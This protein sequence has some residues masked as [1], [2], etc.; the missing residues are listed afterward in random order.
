MKK[1][2]AIS[3]IA[4]YLLGFIMPAITLA[5]FALNYKYITEEVCVQKDVPDN[6]CQGS[7]YLE[8][9]LERS[10]LISTAVSGDASRKNTDFQIFLPLGFLD[11]TGGT[12]P[13]FPTF[14][15]YSSQNC[16]LLEFTGHSLYHPPKHT[17]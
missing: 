3:L 5:E 12:T 8:P 17:A 16:E 14:S 10:L 15:S 7:C 11:S 9:R 1:I 13:L 6:S 2:F 4:L